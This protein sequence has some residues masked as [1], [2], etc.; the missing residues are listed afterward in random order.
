MLLRIVFFTHAY[1]SGNTHSFDHI[2]LSK[3]PRDGV[4]E[5]IPISDRIKQAGDAMFHQFAPRAKIGGDHRPRKRVGFQDR[6]PQRLV[7]MRREQR[8]AAPGDQLFQLF[9]T[10]MAGKSHTIEVVLT[11]QKFK[12]RHALARRPQ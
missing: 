4:R 11:G 9:P 12:S 10:H 6:F 1:S 5:L 2:G 3:Q 7:S 8:K